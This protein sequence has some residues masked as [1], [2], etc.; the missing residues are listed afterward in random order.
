MASDIILADED[1]A[2]S[3]GKTLQFPAPE[4]GRASVSILT[5]EETEFGSA[6]LLCASRR[7]R[8]HWKPDYLSTAPV[9]FPVHQACFRF[10]KEVRG[11]NERVMWAVPTSVG[12]T[13]ALTRGEGSPFPLQ[14]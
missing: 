6:W 10:R 12:G 9:V 13:Q 11:E 8:S 7:G 4:A 2:E 14:L 5:V 3:P 1:G